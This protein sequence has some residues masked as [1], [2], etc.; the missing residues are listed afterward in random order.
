MTRNCIYGV[1]LAAGL[2][3]TFVTPV[4]A[5]QDT[6]HVSVVPSMDVDEDPQ[7]PITPRMRASQQW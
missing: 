3:G 7:L 1:A 2:A 6:D 4:H 5:A